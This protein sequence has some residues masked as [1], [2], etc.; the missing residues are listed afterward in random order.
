MTHEGR[1]RREILHEA[2]EAARAEHRVQSQR[3]EA[4]RAQLQAITAWRETAARNGRSCASPLSPGC[5]PSW[6]PCR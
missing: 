1:S 5:R 2:L 6:S 4:A 3:L